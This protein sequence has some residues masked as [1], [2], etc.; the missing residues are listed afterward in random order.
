[1][2]MLNALSALGADVGDEP[3]TALVIPLRDRNRASDLVH[4]RKERG[5]FWRI[6][7][8]GRR[9]KVFARHEQH[10]ERRLW[11]NVVKRHNQ[12]TLMTPRAWQRVCEDLAEDTV[13]HGRSL[14]RLTV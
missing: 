4:A 1:M 14:R 13:A 6:A 11:G 2:Q 8:I 9:T 12:I 5:M 10:M 3:P 7:Q